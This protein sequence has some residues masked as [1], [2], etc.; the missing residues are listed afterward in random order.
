V[1]RAEGAAC[2]GCAEGLPPGQ[3]VRCLGLGLC[4]RDRWMREPRLCLQMKLDRF[5]R[6]GV[7]SL[8]HI[9][10]AMVTQCKQAHA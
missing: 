8:P 7:L 2:A 6:P 5:A 9:K 10:C 4:A 3:G 1:S